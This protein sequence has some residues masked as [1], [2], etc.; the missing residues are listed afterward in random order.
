MFIAIEK[1]THDFVQVICVLLKG[2]DIVS[3]FTQIMSISLSAGK[4][5]H[6]RREKK[7][8]PAYISTFPTTNRRGAF[9]M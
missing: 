2:Y 4:K 6:T 9:A 7:N 5:A 1:N 8:N 3:L